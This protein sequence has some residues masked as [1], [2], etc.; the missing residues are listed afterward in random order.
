MKNAYLF[1]QLTQ[2][3]NDVF[4]HIYFNNFRQ[5]SN[6][7]SI[8]DTSFVRPQHE[9]GHILIFGLK[10]SLLHIPEN[11]WKEYFDWRSNFVRLQTG[12]VG[13]P[14]CG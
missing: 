11:K 13:V 2:F 14:S 6:S 7:E 8:K 1:A 3:W 4:S 12:K 9:T 10:P 5:M